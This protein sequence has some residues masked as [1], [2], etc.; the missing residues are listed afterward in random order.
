ML[1]LVNILAIMPRANFA[2]KR[3]KTNK[4]PTDYLA[5]LA[6]RHRALRKQAGYSQQELALR[7]GVSLGSIKR[8]ETTGQISLFSLLQTMHVLDCLQDLDA[9][10]KA[11]E[12][13]SRIEKMFTTN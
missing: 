9:V 11:K 1:Y 5:D 8:F 4:N 6:A 7:S 10:M 2:Q 12:D 3:W 13:M